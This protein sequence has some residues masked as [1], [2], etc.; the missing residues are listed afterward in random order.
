M[1]GKLKDSLIET[2]AT[3]FTGPAVATL[4]SDSLEVPSI[5]SS[6]TVVGKISGAIVESW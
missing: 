1:F 5:S 6:I 4:S 3:T 2:P